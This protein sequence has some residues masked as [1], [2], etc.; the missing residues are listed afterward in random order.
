MFYRK[1]KKAEKVQKKK[2]EEQMKKDLPI[3]KDVEVT[4]MVESQDKEQEENWKQDSVQQKVY[5]LP[6]S[7]YSH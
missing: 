3:S 6:I 1:M 4:I 2:D 7:E 5:Y